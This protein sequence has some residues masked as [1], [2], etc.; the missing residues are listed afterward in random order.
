MLP[1]LVL[2]ARAAEIFSRFVRLMS[3]IVRPKR[4]FDGSP[5][6]KEQIAAQEARMAEMMKRMAPKGGKPGANTNAI[7]QMGAAG[8]G[9]PIKLANIYALCDVDSDYA[10]YIFKGYPKAK[11]YNDWREL[12]G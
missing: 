4:N 10:G 8:K 1:A 11:I 2:E 7:V 6:T 3:L 12:V 9:N 5:M